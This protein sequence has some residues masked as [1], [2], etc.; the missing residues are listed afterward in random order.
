MDSDGFN[1]LSTGVQKDVIV[2]YESTS[3]FLHTCLPYKSM[4]RV[5]SGKESPYQYTFV[6]LN[7]DAREAPAS[8]LRSFE[9]SHIKPSGVF[10]S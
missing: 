1:W 8:G 4:W 6:F 3:I 9:T 10:A 7:R 2:D 5:D